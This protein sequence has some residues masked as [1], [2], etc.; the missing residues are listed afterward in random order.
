[1]SFSSTINDSTINDKSGAASKEPSPQNLHP[2]LDGF[3]RLMDFLLQ[4]EITFLCG[5]PLRSHSAQRRNFRG[6]Y[7]PRKIVTPIGAFPLRVPLLLYLHPRVLMCKRAKTASPV[8]L[9]I[10]SRI[11]NDGVNPGDT[12]LLIKTLW[13]VELPDDLLAKLT[14]QL[15]P[16]LNGWR[17]QVK[18]RRTKSA[19]Q[20][21]PSELQAP[22]SELQ[23]TTPES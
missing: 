17:R 5:V 4:A 18:G 21:N 10:L 11:L 14:R 16:I 3:K 20:N 1:M 2:L 8:V 15:T 23:A 6:G 9:Q 19:G 13:T 7:R 12:S 22:P